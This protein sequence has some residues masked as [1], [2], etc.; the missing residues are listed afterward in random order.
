[1][2]LVIDFGNNLIA[3]DNLTYNYYLFWFTGV[4]NYC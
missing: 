3:D 4:A 1:M 2:S